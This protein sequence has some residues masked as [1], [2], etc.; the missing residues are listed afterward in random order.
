[1][2]EEHIFFIFGF[3]WKCFDNFDLDGHNL[4]T[5]QDLCLFIFRRKNGLFCQK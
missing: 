5:G 2:N 3:V 4:G 1:L